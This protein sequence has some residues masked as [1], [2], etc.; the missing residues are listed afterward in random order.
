MKNIKSLMAGRGKDREYEILRSGISIDFPAISDRMAEQLAAHFG[1]LL[2]DVRWPGSKLVLQSEYGTRKYGLR[3]D[4]KEGKLEFKRDA[5]D[6]LYA[7]VIV[8]RGL[9]PQ[10]YEDRIQ[11]A[12]AQGK[13]AANMFDLP[14]LLGFRIP[15][16]DMHSAIAM[17]VVGFYES[18]ANVVIAPDLLVALHGS[19]FDVDSLFVI[20]RGISKDGRPI[21]YKRNAKKQYEFRTTDDPLALKLFGVHDRKDELAYHKNGVMEHMLDIISSPKNINEMLSP[22]PMQDIREEK[23][24][25]IAIKGLSEA[26]DLSNAN[27]K[28]RSHNIIFGAARA[29]GKFANSGKAIAYM[30]D[31]GEK[32]SMPRVREKE[33]PIVINGKLYDHLR[34]VDDAGTNITVSLDGFI[35]IAIDNIRELALHYLNINDST[36]NAFIGLRSLGVDL[37]TAVDILNQPAILWYTDAYAEREN[38]RGK[39]VRE[40]ILPILGTDTLDTERINVNDDLLERGLKIGSNWDN[41]GMM[42]ADEQGTKDAQEYLLEQLAIL[43]MF[44]QANRLGNSI[45]ELAGFLNIARS[46]PVKKVEIDAILEKGQSIFGTVSSDGTLPDFNQSS[47][48]FDIVEIFQRNSHLLQVYKSLIDFD[49]VLENTFKKHHPR[50]NS[51]IEKL[52]QAIGL[53]R[54]RAETTEEMRN[55]FLTYII[56]NELYSGTYKVD[57][58]LIH[59]YKIKDEERILTG[60]KAANQIFIKK[61]QLLRKYLYKKMDSEGRA[62][63]NLFLNHLAEIYNPVTRTFELRFSGG[64][65]QDQMDLLNLQQAFYELN[66]YDVSYNNKTGKYKVIEHTEPRADD[67]FSDLQK[68]FVSYG[69]MNWGMRFGIGNYSYILPEQMYKPVDELFNRLLDR[70]IGEKGDENFEKVRED[71]LMQFAVTFADLVPYFGEKAYVHGTY[72]N[73]YGSTSNI[74]QGIENGY[75]YDRKYTAK[76]GVD[77]PLII[78]SGPKIRERI[79]IRL[80]D[81]SE[82]NIYYA[83]IGLASPFATYHTPDEIINNGYSLQDHFI[84]DPR[85]GKPIRNIRVGDVNV[86]NIQ[87]RGKDVAEGD[88]ISLTLYHD[89]A[90]LEKTY[91]KVAAITGNIYMIKKIK[92]LPS[93][94]YESTQPS[95]FPVGSPERERI[96]QVI[97]HYRTIGNMTGLVDTIISRSPSSRQKQVL[98]LLKERIISQKLGVKFTRLPGGQFG[99]YRQDGSIA[100]DLQN[101]YAKKGKID[102][103]FVDKIIT[104]EI[105]HGITNIPY[106]ENEEFRSKVRELVEE[107]FVIDPVTG[108]LKAKTPNISYQLSTVLGPLTSGEYRGFK[109]IDEFMAEVL[110]NDLFASAIDSLKE[111]KKKSLLRRIIDAFLDFIGYSRDNSEYNTLS[112]NLAEIIKSAPQFE[113]YRIVEQTND[114]YRLEDRNGKQ[115]IVKSAFYEEET[116]VE[117]AE[118]IDK[119]EPNE[120]RQQ[121]MALV[122]KIRKESALAR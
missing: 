65:N 7:E 31:V 115:F 64:T 3:A 93:P 106:M 105:V 60:P 96:S 82:E 9:L 45:S 10:E 15:S 102:I 34:L 42:L 113:Q 108:K 67:D 97:D 104:H 120:I 83:E 69:V 4:G 73:Q 81:T 80:N 118:V 109:D 21:G 1:E 11:T 38:M 61:I 37:K 40:M 57:Q 14:D 16:S 6:R 8:P 99:K 121:V 20:K 75:A 35:N 116:D 62:L 59:R 39:K 13:D 54:S 95:I 51:H 46:I 77:Y 41:I 84:K 18:A 5:K 23:N 86:D 101:I 72:E 47:F 32:Q 85:F 36:I 19:D 79:Y 66:M 94:K 24:R 27:D 78:K 2:V 33:R 43:E 52:V 74:Y 119:E 90:R 12:I 92:N 107:F 70:F 44:E 29:V 110:S 89:L 117:E 88:V 76:E 26:M 103:D 50:F 122:D 58:R 55:Q 111:P 22:I 68:E 30:A 49:I 63:S 48:P 114:G 53:V 87:Y 112:Y 28:L 17:K 91:F 98:S 25:M 71:F 100:I 56:S